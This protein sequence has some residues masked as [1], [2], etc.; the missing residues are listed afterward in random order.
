MPKL[1]ALLLT[2]LALGCSLDTSA[3]PTLM[4]GLSCDWERGEEVVAPTQGGYCWSSPDPDLALVPTWVDSP[5]TVDE[6]RLASLGPGETA[7]TWTRLI[8]RVTR[9]DSGSDPS[10]LEIELVSKECL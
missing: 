10:K 8:E 5:C 2:L 1:V 3:A 7:R 9:P 4:A 6:F